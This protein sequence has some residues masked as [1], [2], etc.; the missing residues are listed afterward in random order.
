M[1]AQAQIGSSNEPRPHAYDPVTQPELFEGVLSRRIVAF[2]IDATI[3]LVPVVILSFF[4]LIFAVVTLG[5]G[6]VVFG[7]L[8]PI[9]MIWAVLYVGLTLG[10]PHSATYGMR[11]MGLQMRTWYGAPMYFLLGAVHALFFWVLSSALTPLILIVAL[12]N[13]RRRTLHD[14]LTGSVMIN[15]EARAASLR[16]HP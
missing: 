1:S 4:M 13:S 15:D 3:V 5:F 12:F 14:Y 6:A 10:S 11:M 9:T 16:R 8:G 2:L 7:L